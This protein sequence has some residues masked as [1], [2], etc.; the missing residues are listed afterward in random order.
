MDAAT[1]VRVMPG[2]GPAR[3]GE[4]VTGCNEA[5]LAGGI[6]TTLRAAM[7]LSQVGHESV[8]LRFKAE[9]GHGAG[10]R[11]PPYYGRGFIQLTWRY[12][13]AA[14]GAWA[15][16]RGL[17][18]D[19]NVFVAHPEMVEQDRWAWLSA[20]WFWS[21]HH[22]NS[23]ADR[24]DVRGATLVIN[25][26]TRGLDA[27][28][29]RYFRA[30][31]IG[32]AICPAHSAPEDDLTVSQFDDLKAVLDDVQH[33][34]DLMARGDKAPAGIPEAQDPHETH[35]ANLVTMNERITRIGATLD[36]AVR[37]DRAPA[38]VAES[39]DATDTHPA[40]LTAMNE[41][42]GRLERTVARIAVKLD[43]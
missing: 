1:L 38:G 12:N 33:R 13:Y 8:S 6:T 43:A 20:V 16:S 39:A 14:F 31:Q 3:A 15:R 30:L 23:F 27:R 19:G 42:L 32:D 17:V 24:G 21:A 41:R 36:L 29:D 10:H 26:G 34:L 7:F 11:Y 40:N 25:G 5:M 35:P 4:L 9:I 2:L 22:L 28:S 37:G 18:D